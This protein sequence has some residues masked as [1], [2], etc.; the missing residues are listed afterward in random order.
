MSRVAVAG[1]VCRRDGTSG[2]H[3]RGAARRHAVPTVSGPPAG[4]TVYESDARRRRRLRRRMVLTLALL[5][6]VLVAAVAAAVLARGGRAEAG[7]TSASGSSPAASPS[8]SSAPTTVR[9]VALGPMQVHSGQTAEL[10]YRIEAA[11]GS[12]W[13]A[14]VD[15]LDQA[16]AQ[17]KAVAAGRGVT[18]GGT[19]A[20]RLRITL[21]AGRYTF[22]VHAK[23]ADGQTESAAE[24]ADLRVLPPLPPAFPGSTAVGKALRWA[25]GRTGDVAVAVVTSRGELKG[26]REHRTFQSASLAKAMLLVA[27][28]RAHP[29]AY[30][31][32]G[33][34]TKMI[35][36]SDNA[37]A[38]AIYGQVGKS[39]LLKVAKLAGMQDFT[40]GSGWLDCR[41]S[42]SDQARFFFSYETH[43][44][45]SRRAFA[46]SLLSGI[47]PIQRWGIPAA[48][49]P[50]GWK[51]FFKG[52]WLGLD[53]RLMLQAAWLEKGKQRW[54]LAVMTD[55]DPTR[56]Y[57]WD[58]QKG[59][60]GLLLGREPTPA[61]L[62]VV[63][64]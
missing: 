50:E 31:L 11:A 10:R 40:A 33:V 9:T 12:S 32:D 56:S 45:A 4:R 8:P 34:A 17:V 29:H 64:E 2:E 22:V 6:V 35:E 61:Y 54:A 44:P 21:P 26:L 18:A 57:G 3:E 63:L 37:S 46:R 59:V 25:A 43:L 60:T 24:P 48:A 55:D 53:N 16:G 42:A 1:V 49:G 52:G 15:V 20:C 38:Y 30:A 58:T 41:L 39:G 23:A 13:D 62:A 19:H 51:T 27:Y 5:G 7:A 47:I 14:V 36:E 28:L